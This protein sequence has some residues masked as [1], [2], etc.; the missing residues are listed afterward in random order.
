MMSDSQ[1]YEDEDRTREENWAREEEEVRETVPTRTPSELDLRIL[2]AAAGELAKRRA[3][4]RRRIVSRVFVAAASIVAL[5]AIGRLVLTPSPDPS[6]TDSFFFAESPNAPEVS[7][8]RDAIFRVA[9]RGRF[10]VH[11]GS[12]VAHATGSARLALLSGRTNVHARGDESLQVAFPGGGVLV[13]SGS[14]SVEVLRT[15]E[16]E[17]KSLMTKLGLGAAVTA[18][19]AAVIAITLDA[20][21]ATVHTPGIE[22]EL[23]PNE[24]LVLAAR[25]QQTEEI[26]ASTSEEAPK[27]TGEVATLDAPLPT[28]GSA[29]IE[30]V[31]E[32]A[33]LKGEVTASGI[34]VD[35]AT[36]RPVEGATVQAIEWRHI[37]YRPD[38]ETTDPDA[39]PDVRVFPWIAEDSYRGVSSVR[40]DAGG[41]F[42]VTNPD[43]GWFLV[44]A[45]GYGP[46]TLKLEDSNADV[47]VRLGQP[48]RLE[49]E[50]VDDEG[51]AVRG[52]SSFTKV[53]ATVSQPM[54]GVRE[55]GFEIPLADDTSFAIDYT[56]QGTLAF[57]VKSEGFLDRNTT[58]AVGP[59][60]SEARIALESDFYLSGRILDVDG[61]PIPF[62]VVK[63]GETGRDGFRL[64]TKTIAAVRSDGDGYYR[65][66]TREG[67]TTLWAEADSF[68]TYRVESPPLRDGRFDITLERY[69][70]GVI[71][72]IVRLS[73]GDPAPHVK[74]EAM[75]ADGV[76]RQSAMH[77][78][79]D[80]TFRFDDLRPGVYRLT[81]S[82][83]AASITYEKEV[84]AASVTNLT[85]MLAGRVADG[86]ALALNTDQLEIESD[87]IEIAPGE[88]R[89]TEI[90]FPV[91][92]RIFGSVV[93]SDGEPIAGKEIRLVR[94]DA[95]TGKQSKIGSVKSNDEGT[96]EM[97]GVPEGDYEL[98]ATEPGM[99]FILRTEGDQ[100]AI[101]SRVITGFVVEES[102]TRDQSVWLSVSDLETHEVVFRTST[103]ALRGKLVGEDRLAGWAVSAIHL[104]NEGRA[105]ST[106]NGRTD[107]TGLFEI[108]RAKDG[109][110]L[111]RLVRP[112]AAFAFVLKMDSDPTG[113][114]AAPREIAITGGGLSGRAP[115]ALPPGTEIRVR[116]LAI[117]GLDL[118]SLPAVFRDVA[119]LT[120]DESGS[121]RA[122]GLAPGRYRVATAFDGVTYTDEITIEDRI[123]D[124]DLR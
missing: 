24:T 54:A 30:N 59:G 79:E 3:S 36:D 38:L 67:A 93:G 20:G 90:V 91:G 26:Y 82:R 106:Y 92:A 114:E 19:T 85:L 58:L 87:P 116:A 29:S 77:T 28:D 23:E 84:E 33:V 12:L 48:S 42:E 18:A 7:L 53:A 72:G 119:I 96:F 122:D 2:D 107:E 55:A 99:S 43:T 27:D 52:G 63:I 80:G 103:A 21:D 47:L 109:A 56:D 10:E 124:V 51:L 61:K 5:I 4:R 115:R 45:E 22:R 11:A 110:H 105:R 9:D 64:E 8:D 6:P 111:V 35:A 94:H 44:T 97:T 86:S 95:E 108:D 16:P 66:T 13:M 14:A 113:G 62:A 49:V 68:Q 118:S 37:D 46:Q 65:I 39:L 83:A 100:V 104:D 88:T 121:F 25:E 89:S 112:G 32:I 15:G 74:V 57:R 78:T 102:R 60:K 70:P 75:R 69:V 17:M 73:N 76:D 34:V 81:T 41:A 71:E 31:F 101:L 123:V 117:G 50:I 1:R 98:R 120:T 40:T